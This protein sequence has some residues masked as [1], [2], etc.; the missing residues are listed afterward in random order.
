MA[1]LLSSGVQGMES[2]L[3][4]LTNENLRLRLS[5]E[6]RELLQKKKAWLDF[7]DQNNRVKPLESACTLLMEQVS[8]YSSRLKSIEEKIT[9]V[10][11]ESPLG[12]VYVKLRIQEK[13]AKAF[14]QNQL[15]ATKTDLASAK[16]EASRLHK[17]AKEAA[18]E[19]EWHELRS[20]DELPGDL[21]ATNTA[22]VLEESWLKLV[23]AARTSQQR[24]KGLDE[25]KE[26]IEKLFKSVTVV[27]DKKRKQTD[28]EQSDNEDETDGVL[29]SPSKKKKGRV[30]ST[31]SNFFGGGKTN[32]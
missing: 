5:A 8:G 2:K 3:Q 11:T 24:S 19:N 20:L 27:T 18:S 21:T 13:E 10:G 4:E 28:L 31:L 22:L 16:A 12:Q 23:K 7:D 26:G 1:R 17:K 32:K 6:R 30:Q 14:I 29:E 25:V 15:S 9:S